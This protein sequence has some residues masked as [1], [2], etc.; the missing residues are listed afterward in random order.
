MNFEGSNGLELDSLKYS[1]LVTGDTQCHDSEHT[2]TGNGN[3]ICIVMQLYAE[4]LCCFYC[5]YA[6]LSYPSAK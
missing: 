6:T 1:F 3:H 5:D 2:K 4:L